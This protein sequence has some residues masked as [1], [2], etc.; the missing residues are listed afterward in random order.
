MGSFFLTETKILVVDDV[1]TNL[2]LVLRILQKAGYEAQ[3]IGTGAEA[4]E[5][6]NNNKNLKLVILDLGL[7]D[8]SGFD[9]MK[10]TQAIKKQRGYKICILSAKG[11]KEDVAT[12]IELGADDYIYT[13]YT[14]HIS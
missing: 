10:Q 5:H 13:I 7:P 8:L 1:I 6:M 3:G 12:A 11:R 4:I 14:N 9:V 2:T